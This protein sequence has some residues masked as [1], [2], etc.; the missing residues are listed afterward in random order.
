MS[1]QFLVIAYYT[2][3]TPYE[4]LAANLKK[5]LQQF[6]IA[7]HIE[8]I[9]DLGSWEKNTHHK[10]YFIKKCLTDR[11]Q[12]L[13]CVDVD[14]VFKQ[15]PSL[16][17]DLTCDIAYRTQDFRWRKDEAL[18]GTIFLRNNDKVKRL[19][20]RWI[21]LN[22]ATP[23]ERMKPETWEQKNMQKA[24]REMS[25]IEYYNLPPEYT[26]IFDHMKTMYPG[27]S[28]VIEH[29]QESRNINR[30]TNQNRNFR[31]R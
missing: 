29:Y 17:P 23:A 20:D 6:G 31:I 3:N 12:D 16:I 1:P 19:V 2:E 10:A 30:P 18:S 21:E 13:L 25:D 26:F 22:E 14:A 5:S 24:H 15:Y 27:T 9:K 8:D 28:P 11:N 4:A 7:H